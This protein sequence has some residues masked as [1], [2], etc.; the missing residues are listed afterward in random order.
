MALHNRKWLAAILIAVLIMTAT[1]GVVYAY[2][3]TIGDSANNSFTPEQDENPVI[4]VDSNT[5]KVSVDVGEPGYAVYVR[6]VV[7]VT[8][9]SESDVYATAP[10]YT[11]TFENAEDWFEKDG[12]YYFKS[13]LYKGSTSAL[14]V[15]CSDT[16]PEGY[17]LHV[18]IIA[19]TI[20]A[21]GTTDGENPTPAVQQAWG[22]YIGDDD[23]LTA[24]PPT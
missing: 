19:Q 21:L 6:A 5:Q 20:Q 10:T 13:S 4:S 1:A 14:T 12:F 7:V 9:K 24:T 3:S 2:L 22:V 8:W 18:E 15:D 17:E 23:K 11:V 16:A